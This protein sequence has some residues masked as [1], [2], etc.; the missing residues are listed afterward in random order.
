M[1]ADQNAKTLVAGFCVRVGQEVV[2]LFQWFDPIG[3]IAVDSDRCPF[4]NPQAADAQLLGLVQPHPQELPDLIGQWARQR[5]LRVCGGGTTSQA[6]ADGHWTLDLQRHC[7]AIEWRCS[8]Q[9][10]WVG[11]GSRMGAVLDALLP[12]GRTIAAGLS[13]FPGLG[14]V[15]TGGMGPLSRRF[16]LAVDQL[17]EIQGVWGNGRAFALSRQEHHDTAEWRGLCGAAPFLAVV[18]GVR[19]ATQSLRPLWIEQFVA[20][21]QDLPALMAHAERSDPQTSVQWHWGGGDAVHG[22]RVREGAFAGGQPIA[23]LHALPPLTSPPPTQPR[24][25]AEVVGLLGPAAAE[26]WASVMPAVQ[27]LMQQRPHPG[28]SLACQ[29]LG[30]ATSK[31]PI[32]ATSFVHR[33]AVWK[34]WITAAWMAGDT[35]GRS[36]SLAWLEQLWAALEPACPGVHL[37]Q[38]HD[39]LSFHQKELTQAFGSWLPGLRALKAQVDPDGTLPTL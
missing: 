39:H 7:A 10:V 20:P 13:G 2:P 6:A 26:R 9:T 27:Q 36:R 25:H 16:G 34:P 22:L 37:A 5:P 24:I 8:D 19:L 14:Y 1:A 18:Q 23:G 35:T 11:A 4:W 31:I 15:L 29:Q 33:D 32:E 30:A 28:C 17:L 21:P 3:R 38:L 12:Y